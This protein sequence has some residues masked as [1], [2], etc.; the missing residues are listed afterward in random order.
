M[1]KKNGLTVA[2]I[3]DE[4]ARRRRAARERLQQLN[5]LAIEKLAAHGVKNNRNWVPK[6]I[7]SIEQLTGCPIK[8]QGQAE[9]LQAFLA[10]KLIKGEV[11]P[12]R[13][14]PAW[15]PL[16]I[17]DQLRR[18]F[19]RASLAQPPMKS[20]NASGACDGAPH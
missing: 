3:R 11:V 17:S 6:T 18:N 10:G 12:P 2:E 8:N 20:P 19:E 13:T 1:R 5:L 15:R 9:Y 4:E 16:V 14:R 7:T